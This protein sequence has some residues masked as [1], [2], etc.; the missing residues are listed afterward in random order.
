MSQV[1]IEL[2]FKNTVLI[3]N[4]FDQT[5]EFNVAMTCDGCKNSVNR[6]LLKLEGESSIFRSDQY[7]HFSL[8]N[9]NFPI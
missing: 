7:I 2:P 9:K 6:V 5:Y 1:K 8:Y 4:L 3:P